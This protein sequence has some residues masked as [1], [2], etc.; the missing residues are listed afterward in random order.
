MSLW[1]FLGALA[2][3]KIDGDSHSH[4]SRSLPDLVQVR[5]CQSA[6]PLLVLT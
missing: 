2:T 1:I 5:R 6:A 4:L 3:V